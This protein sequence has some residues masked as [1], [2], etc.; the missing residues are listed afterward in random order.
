MGG[1]PFVFLLDTVSRPQ[2]EEK[3]LRRLLKVRGGAWFFLLVELSVRADTCDRDVH[4]Y[5][6]IIS[7]DVS[8]KVFWTIAFKAVKWL[9]TCKVL[10][11]EPSL[12]P[13]GMRKYNKTWHHTLSAS[14]YKL[15]VHVEPREPFSFPH[16][17]TLTHTHPY[18][19]SSVGIS[20][21]AVIELLHP[22]QLWLT[23]QLREYTSLM[24]ML[25]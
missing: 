12:P 17:L 7:K 24:H 1:C 15:M 18:S 3:R 23:V 5:Y 13:R 16:T 20:G 11:L 2:S 6:I 4:I 19:E 10:K 8:L 21:L 25:I 22:E 14:C 9:F